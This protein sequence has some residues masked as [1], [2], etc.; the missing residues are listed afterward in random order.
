M[1]QC[2]VCMRWPPKSHNY[3]I[4]HRITGILLKCSLGA[5]ASDL[6]PKTMKT[7]TEQSKIGPRENSVEIIVLLIYKHEE[8]NM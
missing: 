6:C 7:K 5:D 3:R 4:G 1:W 2:S 8:L